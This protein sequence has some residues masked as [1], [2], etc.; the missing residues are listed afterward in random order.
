[1]RKCKRLS[2]NKNGLYG[3]YGDETQVLII[4]TI[5]RVILRGGVILEEKKT[6]IQKIKAAGPAAVITSAFIGPGTITTATNAGVNFGFALLW[7]VIFSG[8]ASVVIMNMASRLA[9][10]GKQNIIEASVALVSNNNAWKYFVFVLIA[11]VTLLTGFG[12]EAGNLIGATTGFQDIFGLPQ[13]I[14]AFLMGLIVLAPLVGLLGSFMTS[15][16]M[17]SNI[18]FGDF[19]LTTANILSIDSAPILG[20]QTAGGSIGNTISPGNIILGTTTAGIIGK[21][22]IILKKILPIATAAAIIIGVILLFAII[23]F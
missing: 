12:F 7:A 9:I 18:L 21:E 6:F 22:G 1:M 10:I 19:Q 2:L 17:A 16:N 4:L 23:I 13:W 3:V 8:F 20:S 15:S 11:L 14:S 5:S